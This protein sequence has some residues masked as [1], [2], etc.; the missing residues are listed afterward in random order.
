MYVL[1]KGLVMEDLKNVINV[2]IVDD[3]KLSRMIFKKMIVPLTNFNV[4]GDFDNAED[5]L[6]YIKSNKV[7]LVLMDMEL[8]Y[9]NGIDAS[10]IIKELNPDI[11]VLLFSANNDESEIIASLFA[12]VNAYLLKDITQSELQRV[13][14]IV[15]QGDSWVD[16]RIQHMIFN[17]IKSLPENDYIYFQTLLDPKETMLIKMITNGC[18]KHEVAKYLKIHLS[19][20]SHYVYSIFNKLSKTEKAENAVK[21]FKY[22]FIETKCV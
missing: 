21:E 16:F 15:M 5:C 18:R 1:S 6:R 17:Y 14:N 11:K 2:L 7:D 3:S 4:C 10:C 19:D 12:N 22:G 20:L 8:P 9:M 13:I